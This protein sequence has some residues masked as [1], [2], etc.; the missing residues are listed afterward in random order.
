MKTKFT[1]LGFVLGVI[2]TTICFHYI[3]D[4]LRIELAQIE[5]FVGETVHSLGKK[6]SRA[7]KGML[8]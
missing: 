8:N 3:G 2:A 4:E 7:G 5:Q 6:I 1:A